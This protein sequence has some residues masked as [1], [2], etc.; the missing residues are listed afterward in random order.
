MERS[1]LYVIQKQTG[2][3]YIFDEKHQILSFIPLQILHFKVL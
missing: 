2:F 3:Q 1:Y